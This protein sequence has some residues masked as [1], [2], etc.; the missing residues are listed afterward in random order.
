VR[1]YRV[2][3]HEHDKPPFEF[4]V[5]SLEPGEVWSTILAALKRLD[6]ER[7]WSLEIKHVPDMEGPE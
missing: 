2:V 7:D 5:A 1:R 6:R 3:I 4:L